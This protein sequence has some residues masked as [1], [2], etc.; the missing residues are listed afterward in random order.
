METSY[1][2][3]DTA[4]CPACHRAVNSRWHA[5]R[6]PQRQRGDVIEVQPPK[7]AGK[8]R[9][10]RHEAVE[11]EF[12]PLVS[13][14]HEFKTP[15]V[16]MLGYTDLLRSSRLGPVNEKQRQVLGE[17]Q[18]SAER[19]Q[20]LIQDLLLLFELRA[21]RGASSSSLQLVA[22]RV[23]EHV[24]EIFHY[25]APA[26][27]LKAIEYEFYPSPRQVR[28]RVETLK[29][30]HIVSNLIENALKYTPA[31]GRVVV[32][33]TPCFWERR[34][35]QTEFLFNLERS[36]NRRIE[37]GVRIDVSDSGTGIP[38]DHLEDIFWD[39]VQLPGASSRGTGLG[40]AIARRLTEAHGGAIWVESELGKGSKFSLLLAQTSHR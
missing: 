14:A 4:L 12:F 5:S 11:P 26:A 28:V 8:Q 40:L 6:C 24:G 19:L 3:S 1:L 36:S 20:K 39:F 37:N 23:N 16:A 38:A 17:I 21:A 33:V 7:K 10:A 32:S 22:A 2:Q 29:L 35:T 31:G 9:G 18:E 25:W 34:K 30:Q 15:L 13:A 27:R